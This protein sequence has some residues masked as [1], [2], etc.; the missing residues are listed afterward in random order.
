MP[1]KIIQTEYSEE[2][3]RSYMNYSMSVITARA[4]PDARD[5]LKPVQRRVLYDMSELHINYDKP[6]RKSARIVG[7]TM[8][9]YHP[10]GDSSI[11]ET[12]VVLSQ[13]FKK[14]MPLVDGHGNFGSIEGD[15]AAA[16]R[17][18]EAR[19]EK[20]AEEVYL[21]DLDK[22]VNFVPNYD[23][24]EKEPEV[25]PVR[26]PNL[27][28][29]GSEG[30]A[31]GMSTS[32][33]PHNLGE[34]I[35]GAIAY[36]NHPEISTEELMEKI[37]G[38]DF[39]TGGIVANKHALKEIY[40]TGSGKIRLRGRFDVELG[41]RRT[42]KDKLV[43]TEIP[44]TMIG[45]GI[46]KFLVDVADLVE[47]KKLPDVVD[48][49]NQSSKEGIRIVLELKKDADIDRIINIL[50]KKTKLE[51][52]FGVNMLAIAGGKPECLSLKG[53]F[54][55]FLAFQHENTA[56]KYQVLLQKEQEKKEIQEGL[57][58][59]CEVID[60]II[61]ILRG[62]KNLKDAKSCLMEGNTAKIAFRTPEIEEEA[63]K[64]AFTE[65]Q[66][67]AILEM[68]LYKL[69][70]LEILALE[71]EHRETLKKIK[72][73]EKIL[74][75]TKTM[76]EV[77]IA[78]LKK[79]KQEFAQPRRTLLE[80]SKEAVF[81]ETLPAVAEA[82]FVMD[83]FGYCKLIEKN[84][85][86]RNQENINHD[87]PYL[88]QC[89][90]SDKIC[91]FTDLGNLHQIKVWDIPF[92]KIRDKGTPVDNLSRFDG[93][94]ERIVYLSSAEAIKDKRLLFVTSQALVKQVPGEEFETNNR[95]VVGIKLHD[96]D[97]LLFAAPVP[98]K[99]EADIVLQTK[100][101]V[102]LRFLIEEIPVGKKISKGVRGI[103]LQEGEELE[104]VYLPDENTVISYKGKEIHLNRL[105][106][107]GRDGKGSKK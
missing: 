32:I 20:F 98:E 16:M 73:Y 18:T 43:I 63:K 65:R 75:S 74:T 53:I 40:E 69:I 28:V 22:T 41:K 49:S 46:N 19:L 100:R 105:K 2:M 10:H 52:T 24:T 79:I 83:R 77:I 27:L 59:A 30:I 94:K 64:L 101:G 42:D 76:D 35:D 14:G 9:K 99:E 70:G 96:G 88:V 86:E 8:G 55:H 5:G 71:K 57:I 36:I 68:R 62:A 1:E 67:A 11:Y 80:D 4:I 78:D 85:Y 95:T 7:D 29:N 37:P 34:V 97:K 38:P 107:T 33:P 58:Y 84:V 12:L 23:E 3:Q 104:A 31:V 102:F 15:G 56:K 82:V 89:L 91:I 17:Y 50:Y 93:T 54:Q 21:K 39:P 87:Y 48:I 26:V 61:A 47:N 103:Q 90:T 44:Y 51:D 106:R 13:A 66:A 81:E 45:A 72:A 25:L 6:H 92:G 60:L